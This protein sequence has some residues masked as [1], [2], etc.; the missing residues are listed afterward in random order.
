MKYYMTLDAKGFFYILTLYIIDGGKINEKIMD[1][2][3]FT[4][5]N[6]TNKR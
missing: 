1:F 5:D 4:D 6:K 2:K 3:I